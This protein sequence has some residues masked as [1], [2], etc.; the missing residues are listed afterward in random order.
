MSAVLPIDTRDAVRK[1]IG[2]YLR[3][4]DQVDWP[5]ML[6]GQ[7]GIRQTPRLDLASCGN[8]PARL[9]TVL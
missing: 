1:E 7:E 6:R 9:I 4:V 3:F 2:N 5:A 8:F